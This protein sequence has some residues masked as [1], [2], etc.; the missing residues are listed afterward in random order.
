[1]G[2]L[3]NHLD[4]NQKLITNIQ[5]KVMG[6]LQVDEKEQSLKCKYCPNNNCPFKKT[7]LRNR[8][9]KCQWQGD[10]LLCKEYSLFLEAYIKVDERRGETRYLEHSKRQDA[11]IKKQIDEINKRIAKYEKER[12]LQKHID[13]GKPCVTFE[14]VQFRNKL[15]QRGFGWDVEWN[16]ENEHWYWARKY[17]ANDKKVHLCAIRKHWN[18]Q[19]YTTNN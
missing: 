17:I 16:L 1:M 8:I 14:Q 5:N 4:A 12:E 19:L 6:T 2:V 9:N 10:A 18:E 11:E 15:Y 7:T 3:N 13:E